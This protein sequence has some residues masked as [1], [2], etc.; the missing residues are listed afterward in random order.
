MHQDTRRCAW[1]QLACLAPFAGNA[2]SYHIRYLF[3]QRG[4]DDFHRFDLSMNQPQ[5]IQTLPVCVEVPKPSL[6]GLLGHGL[7]SL[8]RSYLPPLLGMS[9]TD[10]VRVVMNRETEAFVKTLDVSNMDALEISG[11]AWARVAF[12][13]FQSAYYPEYDVCAGPLAHEAYDIIFAEQVF[14]HLLWPYRASKHVYQMLRPGGVFV[15]TTPFL[16]RVH[17]TPLD[18]SRWTELGL[19]YLLAEGGFEL[20]NI[21]TGAWGNRASVIANF[22]RW[23]RYIPWLDSLKN[24]PLLPASVWAFARK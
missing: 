7:R 19:K 1:S 14:E 24:D 16:V 5:T 6:F 22:K 9:E 4:A 11:T 2:V 8:A 17:P 15:V 10:W 20:E 3:P 18:C 13:T 21:Q 12:R 23:R